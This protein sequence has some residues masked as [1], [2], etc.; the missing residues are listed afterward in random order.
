MPADRLWEMEDA[1]V[2]L[3]LVEAEPWDLARLLVAE[4]ALTYGNDWL[5]V[6]VDVPFGSLTTV[7]SV[8][9]TTTFGEHF[10]VGST[11]DTSPD[12]RWRMFTVTTP[13]GTTSDGLLIPPG[14]VAVQD[15]PPIEE[16]LFLRDEIANL[17]WAVERSVQGPS[18]AARDR[19][20]ERQALGPQRAR[21]VEHAQLDY[22]LQTSLPARWIPYLPRSS[23]Y[24]AIDLVQGA[25]PDPQGNAIT[26]LGV[27]LGD[28][29]MA[30]LRDAEVPREGVTVRRQPSMT[31]RSDGRYLR[32]TTRRVGIGR[33]EG[34]SRLAFDSALSRKPQPN[35]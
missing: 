11:S 13:E 12:G 28:S 8:M 18:G 2:N 26:P 3:G 34:S 24:R 16:V 21:P 22:L 27:L 30:M 6:P 15:G 25:M 7:E 9:Y 17:V 14:A 35:A 33:G 23:G 5:V 32:W 1:Q 10:V 31:R 4:F 20:A 19:S 29:G